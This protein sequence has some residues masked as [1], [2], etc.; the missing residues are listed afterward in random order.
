MRSVRFQERGSL[1]QIGLVLSAVIPMQPRLGGVAKAATGG[2]SR[3]WRRTDG[4]E[5]SQGVGVSGIDFNRSFERLH[6]FGNRVQAG[7]GDSECRPTFAVRWMEVERFFESL[8]G[9]A[10]AALIA[11]HHAE[12]QTS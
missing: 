9:F 11:E 8:Y 2:Q 7:V 12:V 5:V 6:G 1:F 4:G 10:E 3:R